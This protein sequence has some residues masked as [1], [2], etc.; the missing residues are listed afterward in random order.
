MVNRSSINAGAQL[1]RC[2]LKSEMCDAV[3]N[4]YTASLNLG[5]RFDN[6]IRSSGIVHNPL[7]CCIVYRRD[8][9]PDMLAPTFSPIP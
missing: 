5:E 3:K 6:P 2:D 1:G 9:D 7:A 4:H 8:G